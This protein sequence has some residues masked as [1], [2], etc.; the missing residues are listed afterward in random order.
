MKR[1]L[2][3]LLTT[4][5]VLGCINPPSFSNL[6]VVNITADKQVYHSAETM[7]MTVTIDAN[8]SFDNVVVTAEGIHR[9]LNLRKTL[10]LSEGLNYVSFGYQLPKCNVCGGIRAGNYNISCGVYSEYDSINESIIITILQ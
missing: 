1:F 3:I 8:R 2:A 9:R 7:N 4:V 10:N 6:C 5:I